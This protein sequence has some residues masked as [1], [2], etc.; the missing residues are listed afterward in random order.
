[1]TRRD[2]LQKVIPFPSEQPMRGERALDVAF[3]DMGCLRLNTEKAFVM[4]LGNRIPESGRATALP[5]KKKSLLR[6]LLW[7]PLVRKFLLWL[8]NQIFR[9][10]FINVE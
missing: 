9:L 10:Y 5:P 2:L 7:L 1:M 6:R 3:N 4:H 8:N